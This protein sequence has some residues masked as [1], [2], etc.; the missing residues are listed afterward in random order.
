V[1]RMIPPIWI[2]TCPPQAHVAY[3]DLLTELMRCTICVWM[4]DTILFP[5]HSEMNPWQ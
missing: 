2:I 5:I 4:Y 3:V 1:N